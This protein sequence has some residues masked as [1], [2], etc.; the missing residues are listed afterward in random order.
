MTPGEAPV[1][2]ELADVKRIMQAA[3]G[4][5]PRAYDFVRRGLD[6]TVRMVHGDAAADDPE[7]DESR[8]VSGQQLCIGMRDYAIERY[9]LLART[10]LRSWGITKTDDFGAIVFAMIDAGHMNKTDRDAREDFRNVYDFDEAFEEPSAE[11]PTAFAEGVSG[12]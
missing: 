7:P 1:P 8:H 11:P 3:G 2:V 10:V 12:V 6:H 4:F 5:S 9:G